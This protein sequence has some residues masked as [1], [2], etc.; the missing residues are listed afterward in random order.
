MRPRPSWNVSVKRVL[1]FR[2]SCILLIKHNFAYTMTIDM[3]PRPPLRPM[4]GRRDF[5]K[6]S[7]A[8][9]ALLAMPV[10]AA[11]E[12]TPFSFDILIERMRETA[13]RPYA[14][15]PKIPPEALALDY[16]AYRKVNYR[17]DRSRYV[18]P[19]GEI[20]LQAFHTGW[21]FES[22]V[23]INDVH[24]GVARPFGFDWDDFDYFGDVSDL[25]DR[26][27]EFP[28]VAGFRI[29]GRLASD[30]G[31]SEVVAFL[32]ASYFR[33]LG[34]GNVYGLSARGLA[35]NTATGG[36]E[37]FP[38]F[39]EFWVE[40][41]QSDMDPVVIYAA[42]DS[43][44]VAGAYRIVLR[45][46]QTTVMDV[47]QRLFFRNDVNQIG[48]APLTSMFLFGPNDPGPFNDFRARVHDSETLVVASDQHAFARPLTN[49]ERLANSY[50][51]VESPTAFG[52]EQ[53]SRS[54]DDYLDSHAGYEV[55]PSL[56]VEPL[57]DWGRGAVRL[58]EIPTDLESNDNIVAF[59]VPEEPVNAGDSRTFAYRLHWG[60]APGVP[61]QDGARV[62]RT[63]TGYGGVAGIE[64]Q[65]DRQKF[66]ID[67]DARTMP[68]LPEDAELKARVSATDGEI[69]E[70]VLERIES[71]GLWRLVVELRANEGATVSELNAALFVNETRVS[72]TWLYQWQTI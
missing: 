18:D 21:L 49:P 6:A 42:L 72:E 10:R 33:A 58:I 40:R 43:P 39:T 24:D 63:L 2:P 29:V 57:D 66:V 3:F 32:G 36:E 60:L 12:G 9:S 69:A 54:F 70:T 5:L 17:N 38:A 20:R 30:A 15:P 53:R 41:V 4:P 22:A 16:D 47:E 23:Q 56:I 67:F 55:R 1:M 14:P 71:Q 50:V 11:A 59:W 61:G 64:P 7:A 31:L 44:S 62:L 65:R 52:L 13:G 46:G 35:I 26:E 8:A 51:G 28:G 25:I 48:V 68:E 34:Q 45:P 19:D 27:T 37:E